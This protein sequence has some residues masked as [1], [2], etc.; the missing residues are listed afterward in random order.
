MGYFLDND[1]ILVFDGDKFSRILNRI[2]QT[3]MLSFDD[4]LLNF[5]VNIHV[6]EHRIIF[7]FVSGIAHQNSQPTTIM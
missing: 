6:F 5:S 2:S 7:P 3:I 1:K 4:D